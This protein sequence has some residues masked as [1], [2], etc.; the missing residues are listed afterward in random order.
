MRGLDPDVKHA[1]A[2]NY[3][4]GLRGEV[5]SLGRACGARHPALIDAARI[6]V[7]SPGF[8]SLGL[9]EVFAYRDDWP[10]ISPARRA[11]LEDLIG[12]PAPRPA[13][14]PQAGEEVAPR[15]GEPDAVH[16][17]D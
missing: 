8:R 6:E 3:L 9:R 12:P 17:D 2:A 7:V 5:L 11:E 4:V 10:A 14:G 15:V 16:S 1:R 13:P